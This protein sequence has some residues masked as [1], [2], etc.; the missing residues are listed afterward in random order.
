MPGERCR[1]QFLKSKLILCSDYE[2]IRFT[3]SLKFFS[4][5]SPAVQWLGLHTSTT[6]GLG[7]VSGLGTELSK[8]AWHLK[9]EGGEKQSWHPV[10][11]QR[12]W[13]MAQSSG[14]V[15]RVPLVL[16]PFLAVSW[17]SP[18]AGPLHG[19]SFVC[20]MRCCPDVLSARLRGAPC[21]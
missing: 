18:H 5:N 15:V 2:K 9:K 1:G 11:V 19:G 12:K 21:R 6:D 16:G 4:E 13:K 7:S 3:V 8:A 20:S 10:D 14:L 17:P